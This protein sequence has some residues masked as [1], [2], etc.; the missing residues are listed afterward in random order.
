MDTKIQTLIDQLMHL[1]IEASIGEPWNFGE[2]KEC[3]PF[4]AV[5]EQ[6]SI[7]FHSRG[8]KNQLKRIPF[9][10]DKTSFSFS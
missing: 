8:K 2:G 4:G 7:R 10:S 1:N 6:V 5:I 3:N 9:T